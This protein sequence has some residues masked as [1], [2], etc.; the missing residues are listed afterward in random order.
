MCDT[1]KHTE[2]DVPRL[3]RTNRSTIRHIW[4]LQCEG[5]THPAFGFD[6]LDTPTIRVVVNH[7]AVC[8]LGTWWPS[9]I[10][11]GWRSELR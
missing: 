1:L 4:A 11:Y 10:P 2:C 7:G 3:E 5:S 6:I 9:S 8:C